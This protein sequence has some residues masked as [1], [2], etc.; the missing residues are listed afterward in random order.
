MVGEIQVVTSNFSAQYGLAQGVAFYQFAS[1]TNILHGDAF[2]IVRNTIFDAAGAAPPPG[3]N[4]NVKGPTPVINQNNYGFALGGPVWIPKLYNG[5]NKTF[6]RFSADWFRQNQTDSSG[7]FTIPTAAEVG[8]DFSGYKDSNGNVISVF[9]PQGFVA[10]SG[11]TAPAPGQQWPGNKIPTSCFSTVSASLLK[12]IPMPDN[13]GLTNNKFPSEGVLPIRQTNWGFSID[14]NLTD[15]Q[16]LHGSFWRDKYNLLSCCNGGIHVNNVLSG[17]ESEP[18]LGTG[19][20]LTYSNVISTNLV[21][22]GGFGWMGEINNE[23]TSFL[24]FNFPAV[25]GSIPLPAIHFNSPFGE[26]PTHWGLNGNAETYSKNRKRAHSFDTNMLWTPVR[27][28][29]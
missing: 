15:K 4:P 27:N 5:K 8:G 18:R 20:F 13:S 23:L 28:T 2:E 3:P 14:H 6:F 24:G 17:L 9:V 16:K 1:G 25:A 19:L 22:T 21:M 12:F 7:A 10:P 29:F 26:Q 11:C